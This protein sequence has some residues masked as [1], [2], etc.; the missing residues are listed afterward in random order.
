MAVF[1][2]YTAVGNNED[3]S[4]I[5]TRVAVEE[6]PLLSSI[7]KT[8]ATG[9]KH[10][11]VNETLDAP[12]FNAEVEGSDAVYGVITPRTRTDNQC[13]IVRKTG[14][15][16]RTQEAVMK[17][18]ISSE[19]SHQ[20]EK[21]TKELARDMERVLWQGS[22]SA[23]SATVARTSEGIF[24]FLATNRQ[25]M[26]TTLVTG[27]AQAGAASTITLAVGGGA[28]TAAGDRF[29]ITAGTGAGQVR[30][31]VGAAA[32]DVVTVSEAW[33]VVPDVTSVY[34]HYGVPLA[35]SEVVLN[36]GIQ[37]SRDAGGQAKSVYVDGK[38]KR[39]ISGF[40]QG[41]RRVGESSKTLVNSVDM[42]DS[43]F[44]QLQIKYDR[45]TPA[46][47]AAILDEEYFATAFL[48]PVIAEEMPTTGSARK[49]MIEGEFCLESTGESA[50]A[51]VMGAL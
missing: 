33:D 32:G 26:A 23:G 18:G 31:Q 2:T 9:V 27:T 21:K 12:V 42:Y 7:K 24:S 25:N 29:L 20:L 43:D 1:Q 6:T 4:N 51:I 36:N 41:I 49:F 35:L 3:L 15:I 46:G 44:G 37:A 16:S 50:S 19:Y 8:K 13:Q 48:R 40:A 45:W 39:A 5:V 14:L 38:Q 28:G 34:S 30:T 10:E 11:W 22:K 17:A 47:C